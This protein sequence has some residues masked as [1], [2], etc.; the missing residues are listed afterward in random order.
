V[1]WKAAGGLNP[2]LHVTKAPSLDHVTAHR[3]PFAT[4]KPRVTYEDSGVC[5]GTYWSLLE[6]TGA[7]SHL[8]IAQR[9]LTMTQLVPKYDTVAF[10][11]DSAVFEVACSPYGVS[12]VY[13]SF[14]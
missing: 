13:L 10:S 1:R 7:W 5:R 14:C 3:R 8:D 6:P 4:M 11:R 9:L 2:R 12:I